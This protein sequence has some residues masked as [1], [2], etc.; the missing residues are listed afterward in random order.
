M[1]LDL[2]PHQLKALKEIHNG[3]IVKGGVGTGKSRVSLAYYYSRVAEGPLR[4]NGSGRNGPPKNPVPIY[5]ITTAKKRDDREWEEE[6]AAFAIS[7]DPAVS[8]GGIKLAVDSWNNIA[9]YV[10]VANAFFI[11]DEQRL[12]GSGAWVKAFFKI[13]KANQWIVLSAT[14]GDTWLDYCPVFVANGFYENRTQFIRRHVVYKNFSKF[15]KID[16]YVEEDYL[17]KLR[18][19]VLVEMPYTRHTK[20]HD[21]KIV[22][23]HDETL[24]DLVWKDRWHVFEDRPIRDV[25]EMFTVARKVVNSDPARLNG[26]IQLME[27]HPRLIIF[28]N[29]NYELDMLRTLGPVFDIPV[30]EWNG[31]RHEPIPDSDKWLYLVQY[32]AGSEGWNCTSTN[33]MVFY[34]Q[35]YSWKQ[36]EQAHGRTDRLNTKY[37]DLYYYTLRS[38]AKIDVLISKALTTKRNFNEREI[39]KSWAPFPAEEEAAA[40]A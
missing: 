16:R 4:I 3:C 5:I 8:I 38:A 22:V 10:D 2:Y 40:A 7:G 19:S 9:Q 30:G 31:H 18:D 29:Y 28:Y 12:V 33:A 1:A 32:T 34:S 14:P 25:A 11:F 6:A 26:V 27:E 21:I 13:A 36:Y 24:F 37:V 39:A 17:L 15:P 23:G 20:R 35:T